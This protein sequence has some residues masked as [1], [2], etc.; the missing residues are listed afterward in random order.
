MIARMRRFFRVLANPRRV[1][2]RFFRVSAPRP[3]LDSFAATP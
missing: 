1:F 3:D 2:E